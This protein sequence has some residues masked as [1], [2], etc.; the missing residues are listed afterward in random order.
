M[1]EGQPVDR[2]ASRFALIEPLR[3][4]TYRTIWT[5]SLFS[6]FGQLIQGVGAA[7]LM[8]RLSDSAEMVALVQTAIMLPLMLV[9][10]PA[11]A[12]ADMF[13]RR[14][15]ALAG[16]GF[17]CVMAVCLTGLAWGGLVTPWVLL[18]FCFL[19]G[20]GVALYGPAWQASVSEQVSGEHLPAA[21]ALGTISYNVARSFGP[22]LGGIVVA[23]FGAMA[24]FAV[25]AIFYLPLILAF[26]RWDRRHSPS[27]LP[28]E[29]IDR[30]IVSGVRYALYSPPIRV[31]LIRT[32]ASG[33]AG[34]T[35]SALT[36]LVAKDMLGGNAS[37]FGLLLGAYGVGAVMGATLLGLVRARLSAEQAARLLAVITGV[38]LVIVGLS[39]QI[40]VTCAAMI[41]AG[42]A[43]MILIAQFNVSVQMS[44][45]RWVT[46]RALACYGSAITGGIAI[47][48]WFWGMV[49]ADLGTGPAMILSGVAVTLS[50]LLGLVMPLPSE[51]PGGLDASRL[52][53]EPEVSLA[54]TARSG[55]IR[56]ELDYRVEPERA[57]E[58][59]E[60]MQR[61]RNAR[62][63]SGAFEW[64]LSR[65]IADPYLWTEQYHCPTW[66]DYL[67]QRER[68]TQGDLEL[69]AAADVFHTGG[70][71]GRV[72]RRLE[73]PTGSVRWRADTPDR[74]DETVGLYPH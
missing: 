28:P 65:D 64:S 16:L 42:A 70:R 12:I 66:G 13:D 61:L 41:V 3:E 54:L 27:R 72:R 60:A 8:V 43:W 44:A 59:Y 26:L 25:N 73:R 74:R 69:Q 50:P 58:Y 40:V 24:A 52:A 15:V 36:P 10:L 2:I 21:V 67:R 4:R 20:A 29:R 51:L 30:A 5:A 22:A 62:M 48:A 47:G 68:M 6:N 19:I 34:A 14:K 71:E 63:R 7:W 18:A 35:M 23:A 17:A 45:P 55:P 38:M 39:H 57:R 32:L 46:A 31:V 56:I 49:A 11:G 9:A 33:L 53:H 1:A 37:T